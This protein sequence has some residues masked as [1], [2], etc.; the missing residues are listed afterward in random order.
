MRHDR[1][2]VVTQLHRVVTI[3]VV[4]IYFCDGLFIAMCLRYFVLLVRAWLTATPY[5]SRHTDQKTRL[6]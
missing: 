5:A 2:E 6:S 3:L 1:S 4:Y